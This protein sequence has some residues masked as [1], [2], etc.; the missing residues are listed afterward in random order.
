VKALLGAG[1]AAVLVVCGVVC[2]F[3]GVVGAIVAMLADPALAC[4]VTPL[5]KV[6]GIDTPSLGRLTREQIG[7]AAIIVAVGVER[8]VPVRGQVIAVATAMQES[9]LYNATEE[10]DHDSLGL[11]QQRPSA[12]WGKP[13]ELTDPRY[14]SR[15]F[16]EALLEVDGWQ[17]MPLTVAAQKVQRSAYPDAYAK[18]EPGAAAVVSALAAGAVSC[19]NYTGWVQPVFAEVWSGFRTAE[20]PNHQ[21]VDLAAP[22][23][24]PVRAAAAGMV[25]WADCDVSGWYHCQGDG[26]PQTPG[27]GW[28]ID[29]K[30]P[31]DIYTRYCHLNVAPY[32]KVGQEVT[33]GQVLGLSGT[34]G[35][36]SGPHLHFEVHLGDRSKDTATDPVRFM[37]EHGAPLGPAPRAAAFHTDYPA[38]RNAPHARTD[39][40]FRPMFSIFALG[41]GS[42]PLLPQRGM[43]TYSDLPRGPIVGGRKQ[44]TVD[45]EVTRRGQ[46]TP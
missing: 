37:A 17:S 13:E 12:G 33:A 2:A 6:T 45:G 31:G 18:H 15:K 10:T 35:H 39:T 9:R 14:A 8:K 41:A 36:S 4:A 3:V 44:S 43:S 40:G 25:V 32:V 5:D 27:C 21:G 19:A 30:H 23:D 38:L 1:V 26:S 7:N 42:G 20:R 34:T 16:Y 11:F 24:T 22:R 46:S 29:I 28:Y